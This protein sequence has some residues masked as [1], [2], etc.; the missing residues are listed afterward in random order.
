MFPPC[1]PMSKFRCAL[2]IM[3]VGWEDSYESY[4]SNGIQKTWKTLH[5]WVENA[6]FPKTKDPIPGMGV[7]YNYSAIKGIWSCHFEG[8]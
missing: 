1:F 6:M 7:K 3:R 4:L 8:L 2:I 5:L